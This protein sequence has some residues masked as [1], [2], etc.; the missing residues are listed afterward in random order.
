MEAWGGIGG[1]QWLLMATWTH[2]AETPQH[3]IA[4]LARLV[5]SKPAKFLGLDHRKGKIAKGYDADIVIWDPNA[6]TTI[7]K[8]NIYFKHKTTPYNNRSLKGKIIR[9]YING[10]L[11]FDAEGFSEF[12]H[13]TLISK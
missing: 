5:S 8:K 10:E 9:T 2:L 13:G 6:E 3:S 11:A 1:I 4:N 12:A 7:N